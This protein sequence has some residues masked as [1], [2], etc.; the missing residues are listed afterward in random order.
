[1]A[2]NADTILALY[3][4]RK[5]A[6]ARELGM[7]EALKR[8]YNGEH[9][10]PLPEIE[11]AEKASVANLIQAGIDQHALRIASVL[12]G[13]IC[14]PL[15]PTK[16]AIAKADDRRLTL[17][18]WWYENTITRKIRRRARHL[19]GYGSTPVL[20]RPGRDDI[21]RWEVR[22]PLT[23]FP[24]PADPDDII[25][26]D[27][28]FGFRRSLAWLRAHYD[29]SGFQPGPNATPESL[30]DVLQYVDDTQ[31]AL[32][33]VGIREQDDRGAPED[34]GQRP[35]YLLANIPNRTGRPL[36]VVPGRIT[37]NRL[38]GQFEQLIGMYEAQGLLWAYHLHAVKRAIFGEVW[39][40]GRPNENPEIQSVADPYQG[41]VG[42]VTGGVL[43]R[44]A[45]DPGVQTLPAIQNLER[46]ERLTGAIPAEFGGEAPS[47]VRT[48]RRGGQVLSAAVDFPIQE[49]QEILA[50]SL[51]KENSIAI[52]IAKTYWPNATRTFA[53]PFGRGS[54][55]YTPAETFDTSTHR[56]SYA[57][58]GTDTNGLV[59][60][61]GQRVGMG[62]LSKHSF[63]LIDPLVTDP[64]AEHQRVILEQIEQAHVSSI[65]QQ[66]ANP[67]GPYQPTDLARLY[68]MLW[69]QN[70]P[71]YE[72]EQR[73]QQEIQARQAQA[74]QGA[75][76]PAQMQP[77]NAVA[78]APGTPQAAV[79]Q[80]PVGPPAPSQ[81][82]LME[83]LN[84]LRR[85]QAG[86]FG[87]GE[88]LRPAASQ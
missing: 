6:Q 88:T 38:Q 19:V 47:N 30:Y 28:I 20:I 41:D 65:Q 78:G 17:Q 22:D 67:A 59:I 14:P 62:T 15:K 7:A 63:M 79:Q 87:T 48:A 24:A 21:P 29:L 53:V 57:Y 77:G 11:R 10:I 85:P 40:E 2:R 69:E 73:L 1:M 61:G 42:V 16:S 23:T 75:L 8:V 54:V 34:P 72:A 45:A 80:G 70:L 44:F 86:P 43:T 71:L 60:E 35:A 74:S 84:T 50:M 37:L 39:L 76:N 36:A 55:T 4:Q 31:I 58:A 12:P 18:A 27:C 26:A 56:V 3:Q 9:L 82:N 52:D 13:I 25:P 51:E 68:Q 49:H 5:R 81:Q 46:A 83:L 33:A 66:A 32:V 64:D